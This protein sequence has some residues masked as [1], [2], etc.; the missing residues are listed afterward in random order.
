MIKK[1]TANYHYLMPCNIT[2]LAQLI[3]LCGN[4]VAAVRYKTMQVS[5]AVWESIIA[6]A[7]FSHCSPVPA[8]A[9]FN[10]PASF[11][12]EALPNDHA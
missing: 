9:I 5:H 4:Y 2:D 11:T 7:S 6:H 3:P 10:L 8:R 1:A 12:C